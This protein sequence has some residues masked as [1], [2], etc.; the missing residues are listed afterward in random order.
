MDAIDRAILDQLRYDAQLTNTELADRVGLTPSPCLRRVRRLEADGII[1]GYH[2][3]ISPEA[4]GRA[5]EVYVD[6]ELASPAKDTMERFESALVA[7]DEVIEARRMFGSPDYQALVGVADLAAY[8]R[9]MTQQ[10]AAL[11]GLGRL[12][13]RFAMKTIKSEP[14]DPPR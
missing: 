3:R 4:L 9:L 11:P 5:F 13:S 2:A 8:E 7:L 12:Q 10:L 14:P 6:F 1:L